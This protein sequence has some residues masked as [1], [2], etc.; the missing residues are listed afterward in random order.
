M[1]RRAVAINTVA[2]ALVAVRN[3]ERRPG[4]REDRDY[5]CDHNE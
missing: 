5:N 2:Q 3:F 4:Q 1:A